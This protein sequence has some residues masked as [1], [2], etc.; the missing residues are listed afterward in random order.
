M[1]DKGCCTGKVTIPEAVG[2]TD[3]YNFPPI[4]V[5]IVALTGCVLPEC[6]YV[7]SHVFTGDLLFVFQ[8]PR[9]PLLP[10]VVIIFVLALISDCWPIQILRK[11]SDKGRLPTASRKL[12]HALPL[13]RVIIRRGNHFWPAWS[14]ERNRKI[15]TTG[16]LSLWIRNIDIEKRKVD[17]NK[18]QWY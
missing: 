7:S 13:Q 16:A 12:D 14:S 5:F 9:H 1:K 4:L 18:E 11:F 2:V 10:A 15:F 17:I 6:V 3:E 8:M